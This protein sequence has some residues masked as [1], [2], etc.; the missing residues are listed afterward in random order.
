MTK[1]KISGVYCIHNLSNDKRYV[2]QS[3]DIDK[4]W[5]SHKY[6][7]NKNNHHNQYLQRAWNKYGKDLFEFILLEKCEKEL[8]DS[9]EAYW[10]EYYDSFNNGYNMT[11][12]GEANPMSYNNLRKKV[13]EGIKGNQHWLGR[14]HKEESKRKIGN[15]HRGKF[16]SEETRKKLS[17]AQSH[18][19]GRVG[20]LSPLSKQVNQIDKNSGRIIKTFESIRQAEIYM[21]GKSTGAIYRSLQGKSKTAY[22]YKWEYIK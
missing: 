17:K 19:N 10:V 6:E 12:G 3:I 8:L 13:S 15:A 7:L 16:V 21:N 18:P 5:E 11:E 1:E 20:K 2:G 14:H 22:G 9:K 4:R